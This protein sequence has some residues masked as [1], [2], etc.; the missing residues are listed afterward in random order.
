MNGHPQYAEAL[1]LYALGALDNPRE[2]APAIR[3]ALAVV[4]RGEPALL[5]TV[6][7]PN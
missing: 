4:E 3:R 5:D 2:L 6:T 7:Q 1:A